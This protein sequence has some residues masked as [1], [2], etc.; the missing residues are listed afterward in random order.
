MAVNVSEAKEQMSYGKAK[1]IATWYL[2]HVKGEDAGG[3]RSALDLAPEE[4]WEAKVA[5][6]ERKKAGNKAER[7]KKRKEIDSGEAPEPEQ[8]KRRS[9]KLQTSAEEKANWEE[10]KEARERKFAEKAVKMESEDREKQN[11]GRRSISEKKAVRS[12]SFR[13]Y[14]PEALEKGLLGWMD[15]ADAMDA[16]VKEVVETFAERGEKISFE[17]ARNEYVCLTRDKYDRM[18]K[19]GRLGEL[20]DLERRKAYLGMPYDVQQS[21]IKESVGNI[22][23]AQSNYERGHNQGYEVRER[24][25]N[26]RWKTLNFLAT[27]MRVDSKSGEVTIYPKSDIVPK[28]EDRGLYLKDRIIRFLCPEVEV[29][30]RGLKQKMRLPTKLWGHHLQCGKGNG[31]QGFKIRYDSL[32]RKWYLIL[33]YDA[34]VRGA[35][36]QSGVIEKVLTR[37]EPVANRAKT[38]ISRFETLFNRNVPKGNMASIDPGF[39]IP[40]T[41]YDAHRRLCYGVF[42][43]L[44]GELSDIANNIALHQSRKDMVTNMEGTGGKNYCT[45]RSKGRRKRK[46]EKKKRRKQKRE[47]SCAWQIRRLNDLQRASIRQ[48]HGAFANHLVRYYDV[49]VLPEFMTANMVRKR[50]QHLKLP[51]VR[52]VTQINT[53]TP[54]EGNFTLH[55]TTRKAIRWISHYAFRQRLFAKALADPYEV[56]DVI[57]ST[58]EYTTKQ[59]PFCDFIHHNIGGNK[60]FK[61]GN[62]GFVGG[63]DNVGCFN[64]GLRSIVK[65]EI[66]ALS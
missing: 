32:G 66:R 29:E 27:G 24:E 56:K 26:R 54:K 39:R 38:W 4:A 5:E 19:E 18:E 44:V 61:C 47:K 62:C 28:G 3:E 33:S 11:D 7:Q 15:I 49:I 2:N 31:G 16:H 17:Y 46:R 64:V 1:G 41:C 37:R 40:F 23:S 25:E 36:F 8:K 65:G 52:D 34:K 20:K 9:K 57:C 35:P 10:R 51:P 12:M 14:P 42:P 21:T 13:F 59:C 53:T 22:K 48:A 45:R 58:E 63:R 55:K 30:K 60:V 50:R 6:D 43:D